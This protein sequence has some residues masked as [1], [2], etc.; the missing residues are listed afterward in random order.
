MSGNRLGRVLALVALLVS[1]LAPG[2]RADDAA[3]QPADESL[4]PPYA[5]PTL[6]I[7]SKSFPESIILGEIATRMIRDAGVPANHRPGSGGSPFLWAAL[8]NGQ[9]DLYPEYTGTLRFELLADRKLHSDAALPAV[10]AEFGIKMTRPLGFENNYVLGMR[11]Q[12]AQELKIRTISDLRNHP[13]LKLGFSTEF[14]ERA[15]GWPALKAHYRLPQTNVTGLE[16]ALA[17]QGLASGAL[18]VIDLYSTDPQIRYLDLA[19]LRDD[20]EFFPHYAAV[21]LYRADLQQTAPQ[22]IAALRRLE[23]TIDEATMRRL[24]ERA[25]PPEGVTPTP[26]ATIASDFLAEQFDIVT[27]DATGPLWLERLARNTRAHLALV[28]I[29][30]LG[31]IILAIPLGIA[32]AKFPGFGQPILAAVG[33]L[34]TIP[35]LA[36]LVFMIPLLGIGALPAIAALFLYSLLPIVRNTHA[37]LVGIA[38]GLRESAAALGLPASARLW[39]VELPLASRAILAGIKTSAVINVGTATL[40]G[41]IGAGGYGQPIFRGIYTND[42]PLILQGAIPAALLALLVQGAI[43]LLER[44]IVSKGL[45]LAARR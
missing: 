32:A 8:R 25:R 7:G 5:G 3:S 23:G 41:L 11:K 44:G 29:S 20:Q 24:N 37:G 36:L 14:M 1:G 9:L 28:G 10:L 12:T 18:D 45:Q 40:G 22:A 13:D 16:H 39:R 35:S 42:M 2:A 4:A 17:Y 30:M 26:E 6:Q 43:E 31:A 33:I 27:P 19:T 38:P 34:Q 15:D 21:Y